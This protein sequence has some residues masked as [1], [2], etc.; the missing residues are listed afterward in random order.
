MLGDVRVLSPD[1]SI[2]RTVNGGTH[3]M[4]AVPR[5]LAP[6]KRYREGLRISKLREVGNVSGNEN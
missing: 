2:S 6:C 4:V 3:I 1:C 5:P